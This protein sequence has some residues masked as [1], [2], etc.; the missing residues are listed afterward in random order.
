ME[1]GKTIVNYRKISFWGNLHLSL[2]GCAL[3][4]LGSFLK[5]PLYPVSFSLQTFAVY[6]LALTLS[7]KQA[8]GA[9][10]C[11][12]LC[13]TIGLPV[14]CGHAHPFWILSQ[15]GGYLIAFPI[16]AYCI[17]H[18]RQ[19]HS[20]LAA[21]FCG[22]AIL[23]FLGFLWLSFYLGAQTAF[24]LGVLPFIPSELLK[25]FAAIGIA[26]ICRCW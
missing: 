7:P 2:F 11:Y 19:S 1:Y 17:A 8:S 9:A 21:L 4:V 18:L 14:F 3:I 12:L 22:S 16:A 10:I 6:I 24:T 25:I 26:R 5:I 20:S 15:C 13:A 23:F